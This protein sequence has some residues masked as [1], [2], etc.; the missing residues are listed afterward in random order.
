M[1]LPAGSPRTALHPAHQCP[2]P[3]HKSSTANAQST[4]T[5]PIK[6]VPQLLLCQLPQ[7][8]CNFWRRHPQNSNLSWPSDTASP[9]LSEPP[10]HRSWHKLACGVPGCPLRRKLPPQPTLSLHARC[11][12][13]PAGAPCAELLRNVQQIPVSR[14]QLQLCYSASCATRSRWPLVAMSPCYLLA[15][16]PHSPATCSC[17][18]AGS[19]NSSES[20][21][22]L[23]AGCSSKPSRARCAAGRAPFSRKDL[24]ACCV[25]VDA[26]CAAG[27]ACV[28]RKD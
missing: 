10:S 14:L 21:D 19:R 1:S 6:E 4:R 15:C 12:H 25:A 3:R 7:H 2:R 5:H 26:C 27:G 23:C 9:P 22:P 16:T 8:Y 17:L 18:A 11:L 20:S 24:G 13:T 28:T